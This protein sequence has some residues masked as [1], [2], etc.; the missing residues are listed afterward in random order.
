MIGR[1]RVMD[2]E[3]RKSI[4]VQK[5][6]ETNSIGEYTEQRTKQTTI[7]KREQETKNTT[8]QI[9]G[10][11]EITITEFFPPLFVKGKSFTWHDKY[12]RQPS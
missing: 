5:K 2:V 12:Q 10:T 3:V 4:D 11:Q 7:Q 1:G 8:K 9:W 6:K